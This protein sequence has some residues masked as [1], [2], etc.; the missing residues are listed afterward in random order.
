MVLI[1]FDQHQVTCK[2]VYYG[3]GLSGKTTNLDIIHAKAPKHARG[4]MTKIATRGDR[5][6]YFD[7]MPLDV[8]QV[9]GMKTT[10]QLYTVPGQIYYNNTRKLVLQGVDGIVFVADSN[11]AKMPENLESL[12]NLKENLASLDLALDDIPVVLQLNKRD[13]PTVMPISEMSA[14]LNPHGWPVLEA[15]AKD[16]QGVFVTLKEIGRLVLDKV[17]QQRELPQGLRRRGPSAVVK[18]TV[19][20]P[21]ANQTPAAV[22]TPI[23][24]PIQSLTA[25]NT[26]TPVQKGDSAAATT[27]A[28]VVRPITEQISHQPGV[29]AKAAPAVP[30]TRIVTATEAQNLARKTAPVVPVAAAATEAPISLKQETVQDKPASGPRLTRRTQRAETAQSDPRSYA[31]VTAPVQKKSLMT[32]IV[33]ILLA[34]ILVVFLC[35]LICFALMLFWPAFA[36]VIVPYL[37]PKIQKTLFVDEEPTPP[38]AQPAPQ[39]PKKS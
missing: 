28:S 24:R 22:P 7:Y 21:I 34:F 35:L 9:A 20:A 26:P 16:G 3:P 15:V 14:V 2:I 6:L 10:F 32:T 30:L 19:A 39:T 33:Q 25:A 36:K 18:A 4:E 17:N 12:D 37:P 8:G 13:L 23:V 29:Q 11:P 38:P 31:V 1:R 5:T 27:P